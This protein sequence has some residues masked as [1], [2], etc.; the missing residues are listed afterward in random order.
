MPVLEV[1]KVWKEFRIPHEKRD[2]ILEHVAGALQVL[3]GERFTYE[4]FWALKEVSFRLDKGESL[5]VVG[6]NGSGKSTL[7]KIIA[8]IIRPTKGKVTLNG[9]IAPILEL[10]V[11]FHPEVSL[12]DNV[13]IYGSII[14]LDNATTRSKLGT[15]FEFAGLERFQD[16]K[17]KNLSSGMQ[18]RLAFS[19][20]T[21]VD[22][23]VF[24]VDEALAVGDMDFQE[25]CTRRFAEMQERGKSLILVSHSLDLIRKFCPTTLL[26]SKGEMVALGPTESVLR[27]YEG[28]HS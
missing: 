23:D 9:T 24:L 22:P 26:L 3:E 13:M 25:K 20:A 28:Q 12:K 18:M 1:E 8:N 14:G 5:G 17:L 4:Q 15:I 6:E 19:V 27:S 16:S 11:G 21:E 7:L 2:S 10:G